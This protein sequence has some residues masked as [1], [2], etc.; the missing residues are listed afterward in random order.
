[1]IKD[2]LLK[3]V[4]TGAGAGVVT[5]LILKLAPRNKR[6]EILVRWGKNVSRWGNAKWG[7]PFYEP[8]EGFLQGFVRECFE[9]F[10]EGLDSDDSIP[11]PPQR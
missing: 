7:R 6:K 11:P 5:G 2:L 1:M 4:L 10:Y 9:D 3:I 8:V